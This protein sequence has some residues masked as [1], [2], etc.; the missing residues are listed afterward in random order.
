MK[1]QLMIF[2]CCISASLLAQNYFNKD[3]PFNGS[4]VFPQKEGGFM[5]GGVMLNANSSYDLHL[6]ET[7][8]TG[9]KLWEHSYGGDD[10]E[11][12]G[13]GTTTDDGGYALAA[14]SWSFAPP[15]DS[16]TGYFSYI[17][18]ISGEGDLV[19]EMVD[20][21]STQTDSFHWSSNKPYS[22]IETSDKGFMLVGQSI[23]NFTFVPYQPTYGDIYILRLDSLGKKLWNKVYFHY[24]GEIGK[25]L[26]ED[27]LTK[28]EFIVVG[29]W[30]VD[31]ANNIIRPYI[32]KINGQ[33]DTL[34]TKL[35]DTGHFFSAIEPTNNPNEYLVT[36][37]ITV[38][39]RSNGEIVWIN[40][41]QEGTQIRE[42]PDSS[43]YLVSNSY[44]YVKFAKLDNSGKTIWERDM[45]QD[46]GFRILDFQPLCDGTIVFT[47][48][49]RNEGKIL[50]TD[51]EGNQ[52]NP[53]AFC[54]CKAPEPPIDPEPLPFEI[55]V[56]PTVL[57]SSESFT[58]KIT[59]KPP[60]TEISLKVYDIL[61][62]EVIG[63]NHLSEGK[64]EFV[65]PHISNALYIYRI[66]E[67]GNIIKT[68]KILLG[69]Y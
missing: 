48:Q 13:G 55:I 35:F 19:W 69:A 31:T 47:G 18:R 66:Y 57:F 26:I 8:S 29:C 59:S 1:F 6:Y 30:N 58:V 38:K 32:M 4:A 2:L 50:H 54:A 45:Y 40:E 64:N 3:V 61:G 41:N 28:N 44:Q 7:D 43:G 56:F 12:W 37:N 62:K 53:S 22:I 10:M 33:G 49:G 17:A 60:N 36:G 52:I 25:D 68:S 15:E 42:L 9:K 65:I 67:N 16:I 27:R 51:C 24:G 39:I 34:W 11:L 63:L 46:Y 5:W 14:E 23:R 20:F 21:D